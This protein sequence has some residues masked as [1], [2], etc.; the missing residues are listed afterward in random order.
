[1]N[2]D[3]QHSAYM[4]S[5]SAIQAARREATRRLGEA[6]PDAMLDSLVPAIDQAMRL[7][8]EAARIM[9]QMQ[10]SHTKDKAVSELRRRCPGYSDETYEAAVVDAFTDYIR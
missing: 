8:Q 3:F 1:M 2:R 9:Q 7:C 6:F 10:Q 4:E 5:R